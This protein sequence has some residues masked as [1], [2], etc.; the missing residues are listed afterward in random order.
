MVNEQPA[1]VAG[2]PPVS[3]GLHLDEEDCLNFEVFAAEL[4]LLMSTTDVRKGGVTVIPTTAQGAAS[5]ANH[6]A[7]ASS[8]SHA[9]V[10]GTHKPDL[11]ALLE[12]LQKMAAAIPRT[13]NAALRKHQQECEDWLYGLLQQGVGPVVSIRKFNGI[14]QRTRELN[15]KM[16]DLAIP[17]SL[18]EWY[19]FMLQP[20]LSLS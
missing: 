4:E 1:G 20:S 8:A 13:S 19:S 17:R 10:H 6:G 9:H 2:T 5:A 15:L 18:F 3:G 16:S 14:T 7:A 11:A 12:L